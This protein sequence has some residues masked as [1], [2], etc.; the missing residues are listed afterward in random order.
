MTD[1]ALY[2]YSDDLLP[3]QLVAL[4]PGN[5]HTVW[6][7]PMDSS[8]NAGEGNHLRGL[9][10]GSGA[11]YAVNE[12]GTVAAVRAQDGAI[13]WKAKIEGDEIEMTVVS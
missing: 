10:L 1:Y 11:L 7:T 2:S 4:D 8:Q 12:S 9:V 6:S 3:G 13:R 5:G